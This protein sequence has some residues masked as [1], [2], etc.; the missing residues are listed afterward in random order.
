M[1]RICPGA[2]PT[3]LEALATAIDDTSKESM[4]AYDSD[5]DDSTTATGDTAT[6][7]E[8]GKVGSV[9]DSNINGET[10]TYAR[11]LA[12]ERHTSSKDQ[13]HASSTNAGVTPENITKARQILEG[14]EAVKQAASTAKN[15]PGG[16][17]KEPNSS[18]GKD[19]GW[20]EWLK[21]YLHELLNTSTIFAAETKLAEL[22]TKIAELQAESAQHETL[23][24]AWRA[25]SMRS[26]A[27]ETILQ[28]KKAELRKAAAELKATLAEQRARI[29]EWKADLAE[30]AAQA[31][32]QKVADAEVF[33]KLAEKRE[34]VARE[35][36]D[37]A[38]Q[39]AEEAE[40]Q[41]QAKFRARW[42]HL[43]SG[44]Y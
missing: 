33:T 32:E 7:M 11:D 10:T 27:E 36:A 31:A 4:N 5:A 22:Q 2:Y 25:K 17:D 28:E 23:L 34:D 37:T 26:L 44:M 8:S 40:R 39:R 15:K 41:A 3:I 20:W 35:R 13:E 30:E 24:A 18:S 19:I 1:S 29:A 43:S 6:G 38:E 42:V 21:Q 16:D 9:I 12:A 14:Y